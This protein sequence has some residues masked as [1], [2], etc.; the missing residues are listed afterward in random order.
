MEVATAD[1]ILLFCRRKNYLYI[2]LSQFDLSIIHILTYGM[3]FI[4]FTNQQDIVGLG[5]EVSFQPVDD[6]KFVLRKY[7]NIVFTIV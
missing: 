3:L 4:F 2:V 5:N 6:S 7:D 1:F